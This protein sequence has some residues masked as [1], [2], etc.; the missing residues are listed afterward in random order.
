MITAR[1]N[2]NAT[3]RTEVLNI[4]ARSSF[5]IA[6][7]TLKIAA[8]TIDIAANTS[9]QNAF[10]YCLLHRMFVGITVFAIGKRER[11]FVAFLVKLPFRGC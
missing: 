6:P 2:T 8:N 10:I 7:N 3:V 11:F 9:A 4:S 1:A 5:N